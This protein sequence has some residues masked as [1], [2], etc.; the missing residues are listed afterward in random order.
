MPSDTLYLLLFIVSIVD[1]L[2]ATCSACSGD[3]SLLRYRTLGPGIVEATPAVNFEAQV[4][5]IGAGGCLLR[6]N[7]RARSNHMGGIPMYVQFG[8]S[9][10]SRL[11]TSD[12]TYLV[13]VKSQYRYRWLCGVTSHIYVGNENADVMIKVS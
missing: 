7:E 12:N 9:N 10:D 1:M 4:T 3:P 11:A 2:V 6:A 5:V 8:S 13:Q